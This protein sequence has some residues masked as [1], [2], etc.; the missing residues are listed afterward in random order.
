VSAIVGLPHQYC[1]ESLR[2]KCDLFT[3]YQLGMERSADLPRK[4]RNT[5][6][7]EY[8]IVLERRVPVEAARFLWGLLATSCA[9]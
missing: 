7:L 1:Q 9:S 3:G 8:D 6:L 4:K 5:E 2:H